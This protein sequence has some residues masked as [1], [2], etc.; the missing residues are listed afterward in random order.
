MRD[1]DDA[2]RDYE[3]QQPHV[4]F[5]V[6]IDTVILAPD[7]HHLRDTDLIGGELGA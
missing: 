4:D 7:L 2:A 6:H 3:Q 1:R 5:G